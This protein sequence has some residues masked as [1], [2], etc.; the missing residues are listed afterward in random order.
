MIALP[1]LLPE[2]ERARYERA[3]TALRW[4]KVPEPGRTVPDH[5]YTVWCNFCHDLPAIGI[6][7][8]QDLCWV[9]AKGRTR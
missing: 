5:I 7:S 9:Y 2:R 4:V 1:P 8:Y 6:N 3:Q